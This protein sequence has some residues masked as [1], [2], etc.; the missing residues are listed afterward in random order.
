[1][2]LS[3]HGPEAFDGES[4]ARVLKRHGRS[5]HF[6]GQL[7]AG[8]D[9]Q[10]SA[11]LYTFCR[12]LDDL[13]DEGHPLV[14]R[15]HLARVR[16]ELQRGQASS[17]RVADFLDLAQTCKLPMH[18]AFD[19]ID[20]LEQ[21]LDPARL[22]SWEE[23]V[24]YAYR[25]AGTVGLMMS[26]VL[27][28]TDANARPFAI[29]LG[30]AMQLTN[31]ARDVGEDAAANRRYLP[32]CWVGDL[33]PA[34]F[35]GHTEPVRAAC[36]RLVQRAEA[37]YDSGL[38]GL[39]HL[40]PRPALAIGVAG[41]I[42]RQIGRRLLARGGDPL[43]ERTVVPTWQKCL[44]TPSS[45]ARDLVGRSHLRVHDERLHEPLETLEARNGVSSR[46]RRG[47]E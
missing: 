24:R 12:W 39:S 26:Q 18:A 30:I 5:F 35:G 41:R 37:Y 32:G 44:L 4:P 40:P 17:H 28:A 38:S 2:S 29:D 11:R 1:V 46:L 15:H 7:L 25:V 20:G 23:L 45:L 13:V 43:A 27:G 31:I 21:D 8:R 14:A 19:L 33:E 9:L 3:L 10:R 36:R 47:H 34:E 42:Y 16:S 22:E 6:A